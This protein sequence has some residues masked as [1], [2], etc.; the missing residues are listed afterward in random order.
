MAH[1]ALHESVIPGDRRLNQWTGRLALT[2]YVLLSYQKFSLNHWQHHQQ[3]SQA[4]D[5]GFHDGIHRNIFAWYLK[6]MKKY[7]D[8][9]QKLFYFLE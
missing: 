8:A 2:L 7:I 4:G 3:S 5:P 9:R 6:F 1:D